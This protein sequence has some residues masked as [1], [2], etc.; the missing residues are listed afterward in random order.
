MLTWTCDLYGK[1]Q[2]GCRTPNSCAALKR[3]ASVSPSQMQDLKTADQ[4]TMGLNFETLR[5]RMCAG[6]AHILERIYDP[7]AYAGRLRRRRVC[8]FRPELSST[9]PDEAA[10]DHVLPSIDNPSGSGDR[11]QSHDDLPTCCNRPSDGQAIR[12]ALS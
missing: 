4:C 3:K 7:P 6:Y 10:G 11:F 2:G 8:C 1:P 12:S 9:S 5:G